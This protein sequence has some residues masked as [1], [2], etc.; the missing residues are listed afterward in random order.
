MRFWFSGPR[1]LGVRPGVSFGPGDMKEPRASR[2]G[3]AS[4]VGFVYVVDS[5][6]GRVKVG[7]SAD[8]RA[9]LATLQTGSAYPLRLAYAAAL[10]AHLM[11]PVEAGAHAALDNHRAGGEWFNVPPD[12]AVA[13]LHAAGYRAGAILRP[14]EV[15]EIAPMLSS[16]AINAQATK[17]G[18]GLGSNI[19]LGLMLG[20]IWAVLVTIMPDAS[21]FGLAIGVGIGGLIFRMIG[22]VVSSV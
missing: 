16:P 6:H 10:P 2:P 20:A 3:A 11:A 21:G 8:P 9:R 7:M 4:P 13:A 15:G 14:V 18:P 22:R 19:L 5:G 12:M 17:A 1:I